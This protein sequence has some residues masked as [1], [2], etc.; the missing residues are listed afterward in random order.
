[1]A[2]LIIICT[3]KQN[4]SLSMLPKIIPTGISEEEVRKVYTAFARRHAMAAGYFAGQ[5]QSMA[6]P[7]LGRKTECSLATEDTNEIIATSAILSCFSRL[8]AEKLIL[9]DGR[10][11]ADGDSIEIEE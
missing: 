1:I 9:L 6:A 5:V 11:L 2:Y 4:L 10:T 3:L 7:I 8:L